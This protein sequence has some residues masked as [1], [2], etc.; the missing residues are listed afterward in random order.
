[1]RGVRWRKAGR[2]V[3][4]GRIQNAHRCVMLAV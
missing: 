3:G 1:M 4:A 2:I